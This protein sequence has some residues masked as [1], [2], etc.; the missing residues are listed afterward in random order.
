[1]QPDRRD[2]PMPATRLTSVAT[3]TD[4]SDPFPT[5]D[6]RFLAFRGTLSGEDQP[7]IFISELRYDVHRVV[8]LATPVRVSPVGSRNAM[9]AFSPDG[10]SLLFSSTADATVDPLA[11]NNRPQFALRYEQL[12]DLFRADD[13]RRALAAGDVR[14]GVDLA[15]HPIT[16]HDGFDG[17]PSWSPDQRFIVFASDRGGSGRTDVDLFLANSDGTNV[18]RLTDTNGY[19]GRPSWSPDGT[20]IV[21]ESE[22]QRPGSTDLYLVRL[23]TS[24]SF[25]EPVGSVRRLTRQPDARDPAWHPDGDF[26]FYD[27]A[28]PAG[29]RRLRVV[30]ADASIDR[31]LGVFGSA[32]AVSGDGRTLFASV[33]TGRRGERQIVAI[34]LAVDAEAR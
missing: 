27:I 14:A 10:R 19:D 25:P 21:F 7:Q 26:I 8:G 34:P 28:A 24:G 6:G 5:S 13:W 9:P 23:D 18:T 1:M 33:V 31:D 20:T 4:A 15:R 22:R 29:E 12:A 17:E 11:D 32:A 16:D 2:E 30:A 3:F